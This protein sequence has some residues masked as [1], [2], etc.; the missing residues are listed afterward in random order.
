MNIIK[1][2]INIGVVAAIAILAY[3]CALEHCMPD[4]NQP[5]VQPI[6]RRPIVPDGQLQRPRT[7]ERNIRFIFGSEFSSEPAT[8]QVY[9]ATGDLLFNDVI[10]P[11]DIIE[12][13]EDIETLIFVVN[14]EPVD[15]ST[16]L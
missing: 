14:G 3:G 13:S 7:I 8:M 11:D 16:V 6:K 5:P 15:A 4:T 9:T 12:I 1:S 10:Y 2:I